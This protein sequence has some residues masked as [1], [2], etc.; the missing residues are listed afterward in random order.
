LRQSRS[1][2]AR[3]L[4]RGLWGSAWT[5]NPPLRC[6]L[7]RTLGDACDQPLNV[8]TQLGGERVFLGRTAN[9]ITRRA[10]PPRTPALPARHRTARGGRAWSPLAPT[11]GVTTRQPANAAPSETTA[12][13]RWLQSTSAASSSARSQNP[14]AT[15]RRA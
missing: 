2:T 6:V 8:T 4:R 5:S 9:T 7:Q 3:P 10:P 13:F 14:P 1:E 15:C 12:P 11:Y